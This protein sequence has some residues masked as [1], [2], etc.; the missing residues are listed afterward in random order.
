MVPD[1]ENHHALGQEDFSTVGMSYA[2]DRF[3]YVFFTSTDEA[4]VIY[5]IGYL[6]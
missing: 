4:I 1:G 3:C 5:Y 2:R 6:N